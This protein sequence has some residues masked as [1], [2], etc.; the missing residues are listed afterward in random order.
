MAE[1]IAFPQANNHL[2]A[3]PSGIG[4][5]MPVLIAAAADE[6]PLKGLPQMVTCWKLSKD[7][8]AEVLRTGKVWL[9]VLG[10]THPPVQ[11]QAEAPFTAKIVEAR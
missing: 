10:D 7:E 1:A 11:V 9:R 6:G 3:G 5:V 4:H 2:E 8:I